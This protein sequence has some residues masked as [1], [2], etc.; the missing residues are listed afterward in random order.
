MQCHMNGAPRYLAAVSFS[1]TKYSSMLDR[2]VYMVQQPELTKLL[3]R[4]SV[5]LF[6]AA[7]ICFSLQFESIANFGAVVDRL[8]EFQEVLESSAM[9]RPTSTDAA[10]DGSEPAAHQSLI[11]L[12]DQPGACATICKKPCVC[13]CMC[14]SAS[15]WLC[16]SGL[17]DRFSQS[18][19]MDAVIRP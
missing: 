18:A 1:S 3:I 6:M 16:V 5:A 2:D 15:A 12:V 11:Q 19:R 10:G 4:H 13:M 8:G 7:H 14:M 9:S 17:V